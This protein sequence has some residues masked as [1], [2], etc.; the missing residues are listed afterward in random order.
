[1][2]L[3]R[4]VLGVALM[5]STACHPGPVIDRGPKP[6]AV[7]G[8]VAGI[9]S[10]DKNTAVAGRKV[11][12]IDAAGGQRY[13]A[14]TGPNGGYTIKVPQGS[15]RLE[16]ELQQGERVAKQPAVTKINKGDLDTHGDF[17]IAGGG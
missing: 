5:T 13:E 4:I 17:V 8:T 2:R 6:P 3:L 12:A 10:T 16:V 7:G 14:T 15:H 9:V 1:M 11:T